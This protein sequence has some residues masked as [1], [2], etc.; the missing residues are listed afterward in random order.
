MVATTCAA[1]PPTP[2]VA[3]VP[4]DVDPPP[5]PP[6]M[7]TCVEMMP[8]GTT[9]VELL[10]QLP[11]HG[12]VAPL[13][14]SVYTFDAAAMEGEYTSGATATMPTSAPMANDAARPAV[15]TR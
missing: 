14:V 5:P 12:P 10:N 6:I 11:E 3:L 4:L 15:K 13:I 8:A 1:P 2:S 9:R 7:V